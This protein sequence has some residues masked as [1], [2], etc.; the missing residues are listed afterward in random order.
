MEQ[1]NV[2][3]KNNAMNKAKKNRFDENRSQSESSR[4]SQERATK[5]GSKKKLLNI[6]DEVLNQFADSVFQLKHEAVPEQ[7]KKGAH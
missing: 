5:T 1:E 3:Q 4:Q 7:Q 6:Q 2:P